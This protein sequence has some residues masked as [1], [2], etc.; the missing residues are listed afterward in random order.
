MSVNGE[1]YTPGKNFT[2]PPALTALTNSTSACTSH[3]HHALH[4]VHMRFGLRS[5][6]MGYPHEKRHAVCGLCG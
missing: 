3:M 6:T 5:Y 4:T 1:I 2:L